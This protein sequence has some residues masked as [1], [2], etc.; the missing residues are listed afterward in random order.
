MDSRSRVLAVVLGGQGEKG[1]RS[2]V[3]VLPA[4]EEW[5]RDPR[6]NGLPRKKGY[7]GQGHGK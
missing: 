7:W 5:H 3:F 4:R 6:K 1:N 2:Y